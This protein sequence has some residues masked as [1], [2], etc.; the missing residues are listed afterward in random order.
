VL[1]L[2]R[3]TLLISSSRLLVPV[4]LTVPHFHLTPYSSFLPPVQDGTKFINSAMRKAAEELQA[5]SGQYEGVQKELVE[6]VEGGGA[7]AEEPW[8][9]LG[10][11]VSLA[12]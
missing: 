2:S 4:R 9:M 7:V 1:A 10:Q 8:G 5:T 6:Q 11:L 3:V 12:K